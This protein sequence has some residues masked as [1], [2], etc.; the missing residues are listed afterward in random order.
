V[1]VL[2]STIGPMVG[3]AAAAPAHTIRVDVSSVGVVANTDP[4]DAGIAMSANGRL[5]AFASSASNLVPGDTNGMRDVFVRNLRTGTTTRV[6]LGAG[7]VQANGDSF[8]PL[9]MSGDGRFVAFES[10]SSNLAPGSACVPGQAGFCLFIRDRRQGTTRVVKRI[11][12]PGVMAL[13][14]HGRYLVASGIATPL[15]RI[16]LHTNTAVV[17]SCCGLGGDIKNLTFDGMS[18][19]ANLVAFALDPGASDPAHDQFQV[20]VRNIARHTTTLVSR[21][22]AGMPGNGPSLGGAMSPGGRYVFFTSMATNLVPGDTNGH[23]DV[24]VRDRRR[25]TTRRIDL[26][27]HGQA[28]GDAIALGIS[29]GGRYRLFQSS[30][31]NL[32]AGDT[33]HAADLFLRDRRT[34]RTFRVDRTSSGRQ[35]NHGVGRFA[36]DI[37]VAMTPG[38]RWVAFVSPSTN[39]VAPASARAHVYRRGPLY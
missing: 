30:A 4:D 17:A 33:N 21:N 27:L 34:G 24:F 38:A 25:G 6:D 5:I 2:L 19:N 14:Q 39:L 8:G 23:Q 7:G 26:G 35:A 32:V 29:A 20:Y 37:G 28:N 10:D 18:A 31:S 22:G 3:T 13:S 12:N 9:A 16:D 15:E 11:V 1:A 36:G